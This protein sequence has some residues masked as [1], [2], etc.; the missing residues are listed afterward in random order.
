[1]SLLFDACKI[2]NGSMEDLKALLDSGYFSL[3][4][5]EPVTD[6]TALYTALYFRNKDFTHELIKRG[7]NVELSDA[8]GTT[9][10]MIPAGATTSPPQWS[11]FCVCPIS[12]SKTTME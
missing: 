6:R 10:L 3:D 2:N 11:L 9:T 8:E 12:K 1:M 4:F 7:A 5:Q